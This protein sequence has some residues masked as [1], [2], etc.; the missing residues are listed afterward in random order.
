LI[1][2][3]VAF[4]VTV[5]SHTEPPRGEIIERVVAVVDRQ[6]IT[7]SELRKTALIEIAKQNG[8][9]VLSTPL[10]ASFLDDMRKHV[11]QQKL[12]LGEA[13]RYAPVPPPESEVDRAVVA[14][15]QRFPDAASFQRFL[16]LASLT[17]EELR[18]TLRQSIRIEQFLDTRI[19]S[20]IEV[21]ANELADYRAIHPDTRPLPDDVLTQRITDEQFL[22]RSRAYLNELLQRGEIRLIGAI[23]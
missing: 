16:K 4:A 19:R 13:L 14:L 1:G 3:L 9:S 15:R 17:V 18:D 2:A 20:R 23:E 10:P 21:T 12:L 6:T 8:A 11:V 5:S 22:L 7:L